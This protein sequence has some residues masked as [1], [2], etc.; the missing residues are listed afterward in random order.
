MVRPAWVG[1]FLYQ[2]FRINVL[3]VLYHYCFLMTKEYEEDKE[4]EKKMSVHPHRRRSRKVL[5]VIVTVLGL[6][7][8]L[9]FLLMVAFPASSWGGYQGWLE[10]F[11]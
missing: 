2:L 8:A 3:K 10:L 1:P 4:F 5:L 11:R 9:F 6:V 7:V